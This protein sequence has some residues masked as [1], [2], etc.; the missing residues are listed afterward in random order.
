M[1]V[2]ELDIYAKA[3]NGGDGVVRFDREKFRPKGGPAGGN[4]G[5]GGDVY[6]TAVRNLSLLSKYTGSKKFVAKDGDAGG[7]HSQHGKGSN[8]LYIRVP[9]G[10]IVTDTTRDRK[11]ELF[12]EDQ[13]EKILHG[14][15]GGLG[16]EYFKSSTNQTPL[17]S[18][19]GKEGEEGAFHIELSLVVD[20]GLIGMPNA[21]KSTLL[22]LFTNATSAI[23][24]YQFTTLEPHLGDLFGYTLADI[25]GLIEGA[26][27]GK[28]LGHKFL[29]HV[30]RTKM[31]LHLVSLE[32]ED[33]KN[34]YY[35][36]RKE[37]SKY[38]KTLGDKEEWIIFTKK[39]LVDL[40]K[41][42]SLLSDID[43]TEKRVFVVSQNDP[44]SVKNLQ[45]SLVEK[46]RNQ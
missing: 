30:T 19:K 36:I 35:T 38:D 10:S 11:Y 9:I 39:D 45:D 22:N 20:V 1:F 40:D 28:G 42:E 3:G 33:P 44:K 21:G 26:A 12:E 27:Q 25:P 15:Q 6:V 46:L 41:I 5:R 4:G 32:H 29:R 14:G 7:N 31:L 43:F 34:T 8:D 17:Q 18:T 37:L 2:D 24:A 23:G 13:I 16:N